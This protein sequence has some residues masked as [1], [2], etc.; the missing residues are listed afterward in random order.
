MNR[1][2]LILLLIALAILVPLSSRRPD[3]IQHVLGLPGGV[4][5]APKA[6]RGIAVAA[7]A[8]VGIVYLLKRWHRG[9][10]K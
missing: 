3:A 7:A 5:S 8:A 6:I 1:V 10:K 9:Q 4:D 2:I